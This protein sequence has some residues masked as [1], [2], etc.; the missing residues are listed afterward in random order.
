MELA[1]VGHAELLAQDVKSTG[2]AERKEI[3]AEN[4]EKIPSRCDRICMLP[5]HAHAAA[6]SS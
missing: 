2:A 6:H 4:I 5:A 1:T 3:C